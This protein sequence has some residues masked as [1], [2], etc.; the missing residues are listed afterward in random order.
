M[1]IAATLHFIDHGLVQWSPTPLYI[2][3]DGLV[4]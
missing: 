2:F 3:H 4:F 1:I